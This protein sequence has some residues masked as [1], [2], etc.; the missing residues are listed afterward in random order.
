MGRSAPLLRCSPL[1][2]RCACGSGKKYKKCCRLRVQ[3][4]KSKVAPQVGCAQLPRAGNR[5]FGRSIA[6]R[7]HTKSALENRFT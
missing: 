5:R 3:Q 4:A 6:L 1:T 2:P 7:A